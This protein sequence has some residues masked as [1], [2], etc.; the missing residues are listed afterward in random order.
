MAGCTYFRI[1][2]RFCLS[3]DGQELPV[4]GQK[5]KA[6]LAW[7]SLTGESGIARDRLA[8]LLWSDSGA[9]KARGAG[10]VRGRAV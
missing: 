8:D 1:L 4:K 7:F 5:Q 10:T 2:D 9:E 3:V 6:I